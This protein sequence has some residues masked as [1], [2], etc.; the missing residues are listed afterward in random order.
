MNKS[1]GKKGVFLKLGSD[2]LCS[3][4]SNIA[5]EEK[6][7]AE[8]HKNKIENRSHEL[9]PLPH[10]SV[11]KYNDCIDSINKEQVRPEYEKIISLFPDIALKGQ[12]GY[13]RMKN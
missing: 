1:C 9:Q 3:D 11:I 8:A 10:T 13:T 5:A 4:C 6:I 7:L 2:C 12:N